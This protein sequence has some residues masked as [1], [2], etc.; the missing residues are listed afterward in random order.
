MVAMLIGLT[1]PQMSGGA[2]GK[3]VLASIAV[4]VMRDR[5]PPRS[6]PIKE[7]PNWRSRAGLRRG[8]YVSNRA[9]NPLVDRGAV[10]HIVTAQARDLRNPDRTMMTTDESENRHM[11]VAADSS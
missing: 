11:E 6:P 1:D 10:G 3:A 7:F 5:A 8:E 4:P 9:T 2:T